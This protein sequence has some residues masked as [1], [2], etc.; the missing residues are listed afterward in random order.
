MKNKDIKD[1]PFFWKQVKNKSK[2]HENLQ[3]LFATII[4]LNVCIYAYSQTSSFSKVVGFFILTFQ[5]VPKTWKKDKEQYMTCM[6]DKS[7]K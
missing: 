2:F 6:C 3:M 1:K 7:R 4:F 5:K